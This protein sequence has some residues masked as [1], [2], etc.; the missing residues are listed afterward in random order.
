MN[1]QNYLLSLIE[2]GVQ[3]QLLSLNQN[4]TRITYHVQS[5]FYQALDI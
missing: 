3:N 4:K 5:R 1:Q 2:K